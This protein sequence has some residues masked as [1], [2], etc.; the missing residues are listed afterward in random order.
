MHQCV[1]VFVHVHDVFVYMMCV[2][3]CVCVCVH[4]AS[5]LIICLSYDVANGSTSV[6]DTVWWRPG[7]VKASLALVLQANN[8]S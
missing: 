8:I 6:S 5:F 3:V 1:F 7:G 4:A 2:C